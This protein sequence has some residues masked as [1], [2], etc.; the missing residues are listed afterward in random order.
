MESSLGTTPSHE[1]APSFP[2]PGASRGK[3][4]PDGASMALARQGQE[5]SATLRVP[6]DRSPGVRGHVYTEQRTAPLAARSVD[7]Q[8]GSPGT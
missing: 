5:A 1:V 6:L 8:P 2:K 7:Q 3:T 4:V